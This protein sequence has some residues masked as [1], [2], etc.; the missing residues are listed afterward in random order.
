MATALVSLAPE[1]L[2]ALPVIVPYIKNEILQIEA[3]FG[4]GTGPAKKN[5]VTNNIVGVADNLANLPAG[6]PN[7][8]GSPL[9]PTSIGN[10][11]EVMVQ[12]LKAGPGGLTPEGAAAA[13]Q[14]LANPLLSPSTP[15]PPQAQIL[16]PL[17]VTGGS[18]QVSAA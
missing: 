7:K 16:T 9:D 8:L 2:S 3:M 13:I 12:L 15:L 1:I 10:L 6:T 17:R 14:G 11:V 5:T 18:I 4:K